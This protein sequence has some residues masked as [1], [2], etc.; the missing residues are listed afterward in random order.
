MPPQIVFEQGRNPSDAGTEKHTD[1]K[2]ITQMDDVR[3]IAVE[4]ALRRGDLL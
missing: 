3:Q 4:Q 1:R 2:N